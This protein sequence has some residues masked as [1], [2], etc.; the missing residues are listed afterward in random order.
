MLDRIRCAQPGPRLVKDFCK[1]HKAWGAKPTVKDVRRVLKRYPKTTMLTCTRK[2][3]TTLNTLALASKWPRRMPIVVLDGD[4]ESNPE[5]YDK[6][7][8]KAPEALKPLRV[9]IHKGMKLYLT[10][11]VRKED[12]FCN[13]MLCTAEYYCKKSKGLRVKTDTGKRLMIYKWNNAFRP[14]SRAYYPIRPGYASTIMKFQGAGLEHVTIWMDVPGI[15][16]AAYTGLSRVATRKDYL[17]G[18]WL[19]SEHFTPV[20]P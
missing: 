13:G 20:K 17:L 5:N 14:G 2:A 16:G 3:S 15:E 18:G 4:P 7:T 19:R 12:D 11:N 6:S 9:P 10:D 8:M 1:A